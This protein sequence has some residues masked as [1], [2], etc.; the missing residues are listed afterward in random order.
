MRVYTKPNRIRFRH[1]QKGRTNEDN[2]RVRME[3][4]V[5]VVKR[6]ECP[7]PQWYQTDLPTTFDP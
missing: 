4:W 2:Y 5:E 3:V 6:L 1:L 7:G